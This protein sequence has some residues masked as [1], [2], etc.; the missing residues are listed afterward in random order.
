MYGVRNKQYV[1]STYEIN[2]SRSL[3]KSREVYKLSLS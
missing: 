1:A 2:L 3:I